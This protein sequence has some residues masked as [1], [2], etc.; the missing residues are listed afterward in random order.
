MGL[1]EPIVPPRS[2][3]PDVQQQ[4]LLPTP[5]LLSPVAETFE[6]DLVSFTDSRLVV[7]EYAGGPLIQLREVQAEA[8]IVDMMSVWNA[9]AGAEVVLDLHAAPTALTDVSSIKAVIGA[10]LKA[11]AAASHGPLA[12]TDE[13][14]TSE[15]EFYSQAVDPFGNLQDIV[16]T[17][18]TGVSE[19]SLSDNLLHE[20]GH[21]LG[22]AHSDDTTSIMWWETVPGQLFFVTA[23]DEDGLRF[24]Y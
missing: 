22:F 19:V 11:G 20:L 7:R 5:R 12:I 24:L 10:G 16:W 23:A 21:A 8:E 14:M 9:V 6:V 4:L 3:L 17:M 1:V 2:P 15:I 13:D 18:S